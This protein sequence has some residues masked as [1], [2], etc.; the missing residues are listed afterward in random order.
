MVFLLYIIRTDPITLPC[1][2][3][4]TGNNQSGISDPTGLKFIL[5]GKNFCQP[6]WLA[7]LALSTSR[8]YELRKI[9]LEDSGPPANKKARS[10]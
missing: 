9:F 4:R 7:T 6:L 8:S 3:A 10:F 1:S 5:C 2:L